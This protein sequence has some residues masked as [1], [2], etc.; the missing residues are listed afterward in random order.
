MLVLTSNV[1]GSP[2]RGISPVAQILGSL[3]NIGHNVLSTLERPPQLRSS[4]KKWRW[5][6]QN[7]LAKYLTQTFCILPERF[8]A[9]APTIYR[10]MDGSDNGSSSGSGEMPELTYTP[11]D[12][13]RI[14]RAPE[15]RMVL[16][17]F[18]PHSTALAYPGT[19]MFAPLLLPIK[20]L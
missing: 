6:W 19:A 8:F 5:A 18:V 16:A 3:P 2:W 9:Q 4:P 12:Y 14:Q 15:R 13:Q 11:R 20:S 10:T 7:W 17:I 1:G